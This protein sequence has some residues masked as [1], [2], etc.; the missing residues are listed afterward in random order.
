MSVKDK[1]WYNR[2]ECLKYNPEI[3]YSKNFSRENIFRPD[4]GYICDSCPVLEQCYTQMCREEDP[5]FSDAF[6]YGFRAGLSQNFRRIQKRN[7]SD[8]KNASKYKLSRAVGELLNSFKF[9]GQYN[10]YK[11]FVNKL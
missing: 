9:N 2:A 11:F 7:R 5:I 4:L 6:I 3:F 1:S 8:H 10:L